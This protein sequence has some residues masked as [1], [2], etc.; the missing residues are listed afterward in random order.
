MSLNSLRIRFRRIEWWYLVSLAVKLG[1]LCNLE[2]LGMLNE[3]NQLLLKSIVS[4]YSMICFVNSIFFLVLVEFTA[5]IIFVKNAVP[6]V[7]E[8]LSAL[9]VLAEFTI[10][11]VLVK[12]CALIVL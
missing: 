11:N 12:F 7:L 8:E 3:E 10:A 5:F 4:L 9:N 1:G 2:E 6:N